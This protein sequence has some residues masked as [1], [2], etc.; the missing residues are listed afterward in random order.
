[1]PILPSTLLHFLEAPVPF[2][3]GLH[4]SSA[5]SER[6]AIARVSSHALR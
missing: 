2:I 1:V 6:E 4:T 5:I 3:F